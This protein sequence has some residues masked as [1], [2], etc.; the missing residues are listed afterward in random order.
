MQ[1]GREEIITKVSVH[2]FAW[3]LPFKTLCFEWNTKNRELSLYAT[4]KNTRYMNKCVQQTSHLNC[5]TR[6]K[7]RTIDK[8]QKLM[9]KRSSSEHNRK[10]K[11]SMPT[12]DNK[13]VGIKL[14]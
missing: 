7:N 13:L 5:L 6:A 11:L 3:L 10:M 8:R 9:R 2:S 12:R 1:R 4:P 14:H